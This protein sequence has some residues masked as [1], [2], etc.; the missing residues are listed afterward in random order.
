MSDKI[1][2]GGLL[3]SLLQQK[4]GADSYSWH[5]SPSDTTAG[6]ANARNNLLIAKQHPW[7][8]SAESGESKRE[9]WIQEVR[10]VMQ[11]QG[12]NW[13]DALKT[14]SDNRKQKN[15]DYQTVKERVKGSYTGRNADSVDCDDCPGK[16]NKDVIKDSQGKVVYRPHGYHGRK[17]LLTTKSATNILREYYKQRSTTY[18][19]GITGATAAMRKDIVTQN[20]SRQIQTPCPTTVQNGKTVIDKSHPDYQK[21]RSNW[22]YRK[23]PKKFDI[24]TVDHGE[25]KESAAYGKTKLHKSHKKK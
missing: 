13:R 12:L 3:H 25:N 16:Y 18:K 19:R 1:N 7:E 9:A 5:R 21:C 23:N 22:L 11:T 15:N 10:D 17:E 4:G 24:K 8:D 14:A 6:F 20:N 2:Q